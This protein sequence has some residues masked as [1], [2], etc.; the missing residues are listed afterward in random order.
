[1]FDPLAYRLLLI[2]PVLYRAWAKLRLKHLQGWIAS[3]ALPN[4][5][6]GVQGVGAEEAWYSTAIDLELC[7]V[8]GISMVGGALDLFKCFDQVLRPLLYAVLQIAGLPE[9]ILVAYRN[10]QEQMVIYNSFNGAIGEPHRH[11]AGIPQGCPFSMVFIALLLRPWSLQISQ[12]GALARTLAD[13]LLVLVQGFRVL[14]VFAHVFDLTMVHLHDLGGKIAPLKSKIFATCADHRRW[15]QTY[16]WPAL[17]TN[18]DVVLHMRDL[19]ASL[20]T[21]YVSNTSLSRQ[22]LSDA[23]QVLQRIAHLP[24][25][26]GHKIRFALAC[27]HSRGLYG[28]EAGPIDENALRH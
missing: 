11:P 17:G 2:T 5:F 7:M 20:N 4:M 14:S 13:D 9:P 25:D 19:G 26:M 22:R 21:T 27:A 3:W 12:F 6:G 8:K 10:Y 24:F 16:T 23:A 1:M 18:I 15:L 28:C